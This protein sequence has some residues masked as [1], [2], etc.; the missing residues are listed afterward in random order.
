MGRIGENL[1]PML[2][3]WNG[4]AAEGLSDRRLLAHVSRL[5]GADPELV[6]AGGGNSSLKIEEDDHLGRR[7]RRL[8]IKPSGVALASIG[9]EDF[10][11]LRLDDLEPLADR[12]HL[13]DE[14]MVDCVLRAMADPRHR[15]PSIETL[16]HALLPDRWV[17]HSHA[18][19]LLA[20][21]NRADGIQ[22][23][24][25]ALGEAAAVV[26]YRR[27]G[28]RLATE[29]AEARRAHPEVRGVVLHKHGLVTFG[30]SAAEAYERHVELV[31]R[32]EGAAPLPQLRVVPPVER[33]TAIALA[34]ALR[35]TLDRPRILLFDD[36]DEVRG[37]VS[38]PPLCEAIR[39]GPATADH[40][41]RT[42]RRPCVARS[43]GDVERF[44]K[45][46]VERARLRDRE[47][48][49][50]GDPAPR[51]L[52]VPDVGLW[53]AGD[54]REEAEEVRQIVRHTM[55]MV[56]AAGPDWQ[57]LDDDEAFHAEYWPL[58]RRKLEDR[59]P[60][61]ELSGRVAWI[62]GASSGIGRTIAKRF[63]EA[64]AH[65]MLAD[66]ES[67]GLA[68]IAAEIGP[69]A[70]GMRCDV[71]REDE[72]EESFRLL[73]LEFGG[74]DIVVSNAGIARPASVE[75]LTLEEWSRSMEVNATAHFLVSR[76]AM[77]VLR[78]Q[79]LGGSIIFNASKNVFAPGKGF[80]AYSAS[81]AAENQ[82]GKVLALEAAEI[83][84]RVNMLHPDAV[85][86]GTRL[87]SRELREQRAR[88]HGVPV[89]ALEHF[90][91]TRNLLK[92]KVRAEDVAQAAL[93]FASD[94]SSRTTG[95]CLTIDGGVKEAF[96]R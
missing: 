21:G 39:L 93:F 17:L 51:V 41:L 67:R 20:L 66:V 53:V 16:L 36:S 3:R 47:G 12:A 50:I 57:P 45:E 9:P 70:I 48:L 26:A 92:V 61:G 72:V 78:A 79:G 25:D 40:I 89:E 4:A 6:L 49:G 32:C 90:Y 42:G 2:S 65:L 10:T 84:V 55:R 46:S 74:V 73:V 68:E 37:F 23:L 31:T 88:A 64:G 56:R 77:R 94:R 18:D 96:P 27:P 60:G 5:L 58:Q 54:S 85:F 80:A 86:A 29:V 75:E 30:E 24:R 43:T 62:S 15:R 76:A 35:G 22:R 19:A 44:K 33:E 7:V 83:G 13:G 38:I 52:L 71:A 63:A 34:P 82:L 69:Q 14:E 87:W 91:A 95:A 59:P 11:C 8:L 28:F 1:P 81:K